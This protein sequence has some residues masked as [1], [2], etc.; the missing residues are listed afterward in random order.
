MKKQEIR[1]LFRERRRAL[2]PKELDDKSTS[3]CHQL[4]SSFQLE[5]KTVSLFLP[6]ERHKEI[7]TY[8]ILEKGISIG[9]R[10][11]IPKSNFSN[12]SM[13]HYV[14]EP[15]S[16]LVLNDL[17]IPEPNGGKVLKDSDFDIVIVPLLAI[18]SRG[19]R[20]GYGK[21]FYDRFLEQCS[22]K[23]IKIGLHLFEDFCE[24]DDVSPLDFPLDY[25]ITPTKT[26]RFE[27][28]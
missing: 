9:T 7:N 5:G 15:G 10:I 8:E 2:T 26:I 6:I 27:R 14:Y 11:G 20:I 28:T 21:G 13:K 23:C 3:I 22:P 1:L 12:A 16:Q 17:G 25:C 18:D 24:I 19:N 4:F